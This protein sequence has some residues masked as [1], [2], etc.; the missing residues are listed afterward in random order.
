MG[1]KELRA[2][3]ASTTGVTASGQCFRWQTLWW[4]DCRLEDTW[5]AIPC[6]F[7]ALAALG[8]PM[9]SLL[10]ETARLWAL[11]WAEGCRMRMRPSAHPPHPCVSIFAARR[12]SWEEPQSGAASTGPGAEVQRGQH[13]AAHPGHAALRHAGTDQQHLRAD[14]LGLAQPHLPQ[15]C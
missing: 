5:G 11:Q 3:Q 12:G 6:A 13:P 2:R 10:R 9:C 8:L 1:S 4:W 15:P 7:T 14:R